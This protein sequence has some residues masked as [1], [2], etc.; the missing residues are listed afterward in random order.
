MLLS[1]ENPGMRLSNGT[2]VFLDRLEEASYSIEDVA[3]VLGRVQRF[4]CHA[5]Q[6]YSV[7]EH[8]WHA[9]HLY[10]INPKG[11]L[12]HDAAE[13]LTGDIPTP[14]KKRCEGIKQIEALIDADLSRRFAYIEVDST[15]KIIDTLLFQLEHSYLFSQPRVYNV[16]IKFYNWQEE[17]ATE[18]F[19]ER[20][21]EL[22]NIRSTT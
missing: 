7:A 12:M 20:F 3:E 6:K 17:E 4:N 11:A 8:C 15:F 1:P 13:F 10:V 14:I 18:R 21:Y 16:P 9:S 5:P 19:L 2:V 22:S